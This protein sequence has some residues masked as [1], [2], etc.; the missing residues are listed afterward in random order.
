MPFHCEILESHRLVYVIGDGV[1]TFDDFLRHF[2]DLADDARY[3]TPMLKLVRYLSPNVVDLSYSEAKAIPR[4]KKQY[5]DRFKGERCAVVA[6]SDLDFGTAR[7]SEG[8]TDESGVEL[9]AFR[10]A[11]AALA[12]LNI[13]QNDDEFRCWF[14]AIEDKIVA[15]TLFEPAD[16][17]QDQPASDS[18]IVTEPELRHIE[19]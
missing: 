8:Y 9:S 16:D 4:R 2:Q 13:D 6:I 10:S 14:D 3:R 19:K 17:H 7:V 15:G 12:W 5:D 11:A 18:P 1:V